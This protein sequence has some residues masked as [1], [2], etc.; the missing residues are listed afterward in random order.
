MDIDFS[1]ITLDNNIRIVL[2][3]FST[4]NAVAANFIF[5][6]GS[7]YEDDEFA[8][9]SHLFEHMLFK[10][11]KKRRSP[12]EIS[13]V[14]ENTGGVI[15]A[16]TDKEITGYWANFPKENTFE[17]IDL[18]SD[19]IQNSLMKEND[20]N[21]EK[22][23]VIEEIKSS[24][25]NPYSLCN[26]NFEKINWKNHSMGRDI[27]GS[28]KSVRSISLSY[29]DSFFK[30]FYT[31]DNLVVSI[32]G[33]IDKNKVIDQ[34]NNNFIN[35]KSIKQN[36]DNPVKEILGF[37]QISV[38]KEMEQSI[39]TLGFKSPSYM[40]E[41]KYAL[42]LVSIILGESMSSRLFEEIREN[43]GLVYDIHSSINLHS[44]TGVICF[45][46]GVDD[47][48]LFEVIKLIFAE[49]DKIKNS[50]VDEIEL[51]TAKKLAIGR[52]LLR[53]ENS[54][55]ISGYLGSQKIVSN[56]ITDVEEVIQK[57]NNVS[58]YEITNLAKEIFINEKL[59]ISKV[60]PKNSKVVDFS[61]ITL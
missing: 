33:N 16:F 54:R 60:G 53:L 29:L 19:I 42:S 46:A 4:T 56:K 59:C 47:K 30:K 20:L 34:I 27:A 41:K 35:F 25:D 28:E 37:D 17:S 57:I 45:E 51:N 43:R 15:N 49:L 21:L 22:N 5:G 55:A 10:G 6:V 44:D 2:S 11:T 3:E 31:P 58:L 39:I 23:V 40:D 50:N 52:L 1:E 13:S 26:L 14:I 32:S 38:D 18:F 7:R 12:K 9:A 8:G 24:L 48:N 61:N 36:I